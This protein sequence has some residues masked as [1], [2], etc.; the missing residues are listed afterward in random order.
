MNNRE[1]RHYNFQKSDNYPR[2]LKPRFLSIRRVR[3][4]GI[5]L[6]QLLRPPLHLVN[7]R[8]SRM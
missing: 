3:R 6:A 8:R 1:N 4:H 5:E 7:Q 2:T